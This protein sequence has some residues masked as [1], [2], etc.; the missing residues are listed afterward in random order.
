MKKTFL[1]PLLLLPLFAYADETQIA[2]STATSSIGIAKEELF[3]SCSQD[4]IELRDTKLAVARGTYNNTMNT[5]LVERKNAEKTAIAIKNE[6]ERKAVIKESVESYRSQVKEAQNIF[7]DTRKTVWQN[8]E[9]DTKKCRELLDE[10][11]TVREETD[12]AAA[13]KINSETREVKKES[14]E[15][16][17]AESIISSI[18]SLFGKE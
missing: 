2:S 13:E 12:E 7:T 1:I 6:K 5:L 9:T 4:A 15:K 3:T 18:K 17:I 16:T 8:F 10:E 14:S 11:T